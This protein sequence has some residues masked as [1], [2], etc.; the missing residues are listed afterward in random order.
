MTIQNIYFVA[1]LVIEPFALDHNATYYSF[2]NIALNSFYSQQNFSQWSFFSTRQKG[3][4][5]GILINFKAIMVSR[6]DRLVYR[7]SKLSHSYSL[8]IL[9][10]FFNRNDSGNLM[11]IIIFGKIHRN[12][13]K[14]IVQFK[15]LSF[16]CKKKEIYQEKLFAKT[17][18]KM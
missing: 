10:Q 6:Q 17:K 9:L 12:A 11:I 2:Y 13:L 16:V 15:R 14:L 18:D 8:I 4:I 3:R 5:V 1:L 7:N